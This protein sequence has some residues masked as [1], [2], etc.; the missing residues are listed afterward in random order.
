MQLEAGKRYVRRDGRVTN[1]LADLESPCYPFVDP[2]DGSEYTE[3]GRFHI[4]SKG[5]GPKDILH[6]L[7]KPPVKP[8][9]VIQ[10]AGDRYSQALCDDGTIWRQT[11]QNTWQQLPPIPQPE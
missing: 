2:S 7:G 9:K 4:L 1:P 3:D 6:E 8:R 10:I 11:S 5:Y